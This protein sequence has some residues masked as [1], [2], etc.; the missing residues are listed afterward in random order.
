[1]F[2][3]SIYFFGLTFLDKGKQISKHFIIIRYI[4]SFIFCIFLPFKS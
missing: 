4:V 2:V 1:M 3:S